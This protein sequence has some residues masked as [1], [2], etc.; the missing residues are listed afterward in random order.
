[1]ELICTVVAR[2]LIQRHDETTPLLTRHW[3]LGVVQAGVEVGLQAIQPHHDGAAE[4]SVVARDPQ[5]R[6]EVAEDP[7]RLHKVVHG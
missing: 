7:R 4:L 1:M 6:E 3:P 5:P 2:Y